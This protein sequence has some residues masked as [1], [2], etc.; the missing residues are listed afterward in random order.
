MNNVI[1]PPFAFAIDPNLNNIAFRIDRTPP[2]NVYRINLNNGN[3]MLV[4]TLPTRFAPIVDISIA[5]A[6]TAQMA[7]L[8]GQNRVVYVTKSN[9]AISND[10]EIVLP[11]SASN[12]VGIFANSSSI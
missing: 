10:Q 1:P 3:Q 12:V 8:Y 11:A 6:M 9:A 2:L 5:P 4:G 7:V